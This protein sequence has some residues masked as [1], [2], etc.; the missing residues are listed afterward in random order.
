MTSAAH[1]GQYCLSTLPPGCCITTVAASA[2]WQF[3][4]SLSTTFFL[5]NH[6]YTHTHTQNLLIFIYLVLS[7]KVSE[8]EKWRK[9]SFVGCEGE[10][11]ESAGA[12]CGDDILLMWRWRS[13]CG[14]MALLL[15]FFMARWYGWHVLTATC[16]ARVERER[17]KGVDYREI[18]IYRGVSIAR[19]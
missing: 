5:Y 18:Y 9:R 6:T 8:W 17:C 4:I 19:I 12:G 7:R 11:K 3:P 13:V 14:R 2:A 16:H 15:L 1:I 10:G